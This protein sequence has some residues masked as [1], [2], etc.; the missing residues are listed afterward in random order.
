M[1]SPFIAVDAS[2]D[3][4]ARARALR[5]CWAG[6]MEGR[7]GAGQTPPHERPGGEVRPVIERSWR[8]LLARGIDPEHLHPR[9]ALPAEQL[10][11]ARAASPLATVIDALRGCLLRFADDAE[12]VMVVVD[13][14]GTILWLEGHRRVRWRADGIEFREGMLWTEESAGTNAI[15][16]ALAIAHPVQVF[17]AEH[18]LANQHSWWCSAAPIHDPLSGA[19]LGVVDLSGPLRTAHPHSLALVM[20]AAGLAESIL[21]RAREE[22]D[23][24]LRSAFSQWTAAAGRAAL[25]AQDGRVLA[26]RPEGWVRGRIA[27]PGE[28]GASLPS[29]ERAEAEPFE[30]GSWIVRPAA[31]ALPRDGRPLLRLRLLGRAP[32][33]ARLGA[34]PPVALSLRHAEVLALLALHPEGLSCEQLAC[35]LYGDS[36]RPVSARAEISR[37]RALLGGALRARPYRLH[38]TVSADFLELEERLVRGDVAGALAAYRG[39]LLA[40]STAPRIERAR[41]ELELALAAA[42]QRSP[43]CLW[44]WLQTEAG[45]E[46]ARAMAAFLRAVRPGDPRRELI[47]A[48]LRALRHA[49]SASPAS[50]PSTPACPRRRCCGRPSRWPRR[51]GYPE[52][53][54]RSA[55]RLTFRRCW[56]GATRSSSGSTTP[57]SCRGCR[58]GASSWSGGRGAWTERDACGSRNDCC[59][60][61][62]RSCWPPAATP[63]G[64]LSR[65]L[66][67]RAPGQAVRRPRRA[68]SPRACWC[69]AAAWSAWRWRRRGRRSDRGSR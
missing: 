51:G 33:E 63:C 26:S 7:P 9:W 16:T 46:D 24:R 60:R 32:Y 52:S 12:H 5:R 3:L 36:G 17:S 54:R 59:G 11:D 4:R 47:A 20:A 61:A 8:R 41:G 15:G 34:A 39:P 6:A 18:F 30:E 67:A 50:A 2:T 38:A 40:D 62:T 58:A 69:S 10:A 28:G 68:R 56:Q 35:H 65:D 37:L 25:V 48:R 55:R 45:R 66:R 64:R 44:R 27:P 22:A 49:E 14:E 19:L 31:G 21:R 13:G 53:P 43:G 42:A 1:H 23:E 29:G 57:T